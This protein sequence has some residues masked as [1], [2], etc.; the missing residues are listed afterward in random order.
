M[1]R[2]ERGQSFRCPS[3]STGSSE[4]P[5]LGI[6]TRSHQNTQADAVRSGNNRKQTKRMDEERWSL[7]EEAG[8]ESG[9]LNAI[10]S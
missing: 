4:S 10:R 8:V 9:V 3:T 5:R 1:D 6:P 7:L 2:K